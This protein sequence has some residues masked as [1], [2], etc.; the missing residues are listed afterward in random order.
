MTIQTTPET[1]GPAPAESLG[2]RQRE[3]VVR[4]VDMAAR[5]AEERAR[6]DHDLAQKLENAERV[7]RET[8]RETDEHARAATEQTEHERQTKTAEMSAAFDKQAADAVRA[9]QQARGEAIAELDSAQRLAEEG[10]RDAA[11]L[12]E[13]TYE[14]GAEQPRQE[15]ERVRGLVRA[16][17]AKLDSIEAHAARLAG[18]RVPMPTSHPAEDEPDP[19][20]DEPP[21]DLMARHRE[22][23]FERLQKLRGPTLHGFFRVG[24]PVFL[25]FIAAAGAGIY[26]GLKTGLGQPLLTGGF[27]LAAGAVV[28]VLMLPLRALALGAT[29]RKLEPLAADLLEAR[30]LGRAAVRMAQQNK[31]EIERAIAE[32]RESEVKAGRAKY[33][34]RLARVK[35]RRDQILARLDRRHAM[36]AAEIKKRREVELAAVAEHAELRRAEIERERSRVHDEAEK[37]RAA[38]VDRAHA[39]HDKALAELREQWRAALRDIGEIIDEVEREMNAAC[40]AWDTPEWSLWTPPETPA[41]AARIGAFNADLARLPGGV[42]EDETMME[43]LPSVFTPAAL[44]DFPDHA[45]LLIKADPSARDETLAV[46]RNA[47]LRVLTALPP[48]KARLTMIDPVGLGQSF[49]GFMRL[50]DHDERL[51]GSRI[52]TESRHVEQRLADLTE[53]ME[54]VIQKYLRNEFPSIEAYN[55]Q[56]GEIAEPYR[57]LVVADFPTGFT[58]EAARRLASIIE[59]GPR[60]GV[61][62]LIHQDP[63]GKL[64][65]T[66][67]QEDIDAGCSVVEHTP[68]EDEQGRFVWRD[69]AFEQLPLNLENP[70]SDDEAARILDLVGAASLESGKVEV[71][72]R[73]LAPEEGDLWS[74][75]CDEQLRIPLGRAGA[76]KLQHMTLGKGTNQHVL[77]A[78]KTGSGKSTLLHVMVTAAA[79][80]YSPDEVEFYLV[81]FKKGVEFK[82][83]C[84]GA[85][86]HVRAVAVESDREFGLSVLHR[87]DEELKR[88]GDL[89]RELGVQSIGAARKALKEAGRDEALPRTLLVID[90]FQEFFTEDDKLAQ[91]AGLLLDRLVRQGRAF[92]MHVLLGSQTLSGAYSLA[93]STVGQMAVR[94]ALQCSE[95]DSYLILSEDN[96]AARLLNRPG[97]AIYNDSNGTVE[98]N[99]P[100]QVCWLPDAERDE[101]LAKVRTTAAT[102]PHHPAPPTI[103]FEGNVPADLSD[104]QELL[105]CL[106]PD[107][108]PPRAARAWIGEPVAIKPPTGALLRRQAGSN[109]LVVGQQDD[110]SRA[111][112]ASSLVGL[113]AQHAPKPAGV[114]IA[115]LD[116]TPP[117]DPAAEAVEK[118]VDALAAAGSLDVSFGRVRQAASVVADFE[119]ELRRREA[120]DSAAHDPWYLLILGLQR[121]RDLRKKDDDFSFSFS[122]SDDDEGDSA[123]PATQLADIL[124]DGPP[125]GLHVIAWCDTGSSLTRTFDRTAVGQFEQ[126]AVLQMS[127]ADSS[128]LI[129]SPAAGKL[130]MNRGL[131]F[132]EELGTLEKFR[133]YRLPSEDLIARVVDALRR[134]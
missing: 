134:S 97:E 58:E 120:D 125:L 84:D 101:M 15:L 114:K 24:G 76:T 16:E 36:I 51:V 59:S 69:E 109:L 72:F 79:L 99:S 94:I 12:A 14:G 44:L 127:T 28:L 116:S 10:L 64:P 96:A 57:F 18:P 133:P 47:V 38:A 117:D 34:N 45:S 48:G 92:G 46:L 90:E 53:H 61:F 52:W 32:R 85:L 19:E 54:T 5:R 126:R 50:A 83:Y 75:T 98:G 7:Y 131:L 87:L 49:A 121:F 43:G 2:Q 124:R 62:V 122:S 105:A 107:A 112:L 9:H 55:R 91:D 68:D 37:A 130:G 115:F 13:A 100:F 118:I 108:E 103:V 89:F 70:P 123:S 88:R 128:N 22:R 78:G 23:A 11:W 129:D 40:P 39:E 3:A 65:E 71:P 82:A 66:I 113:T 30:R 67:T 119:A 93:R 1:R 86:P 80:W 8:I 77:L 17:F 4:L 6:I 132:N 42:P 102:H 111:M 63:R 35:Q 110:T 106:D 25:I 41:P 95:T 56:A 81:D 74:R 21:I 104:N 27:T 33:E 60:C 26:H 29:K 31:A 73:V 20:T